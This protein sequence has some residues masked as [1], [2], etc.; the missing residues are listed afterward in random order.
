MF[1]AFTEY[2]NI[3]LKIKSKKNYELL[4]VF[5]WADY[6]DVVSSGQQHHKQVCLRK[7]LLFFVC[8]FLSP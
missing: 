4:P 6:F 2:I 7:G 5:P 3:K 8:F 1:L